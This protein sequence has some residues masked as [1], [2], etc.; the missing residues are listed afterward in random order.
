MAKSKGRVTIYYSKQFN[1]FKIVPIRDVYK[2]KYS[3]FFSKEKHDY[4][5][6]TI[7]NIKDEIQLYRLKDEIHFLPY[8]PVRKLY[9]MNTLEAFDYYSVE[10]DYK[11]PY[12]SKIRSDLE[13]VMTKDIPF[14][15]NGRI[16]LYHTYKILGFIRDTFLAYELSN[17]SDFIK[18]SI[19]RFKKAKQSFKLEYKKY[20]KR[21]LKHKKKNKT[22]TTKLPSSH[23]LTAFVYRTLYYRVKYLKFFLS[24]FAMVG[25]DNLK[26][27]NNN[28]YESNEIKEALTI[29]MSGKVTKEDCANSL[30][31]ILYYYL[32][33]KMRFSKS[34]ALIYSKYLA[35]N[36]FGKVNTYKGS[37]LLS[38]IHIKEV[39]GSHVVFNSS[40]KTIM[41]TEP[42]K[43]YIEHAV[44]QSMQE[45]NIDTNKFPTNEIKPLIN[46]PLKSYILMTPIELL[47]KY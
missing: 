13:Y 32:L 8:L 4:V 19:A 16:Y 6:N 28:D 11:I 26:M 14:K 22:L 25:I 36:I 18:N 2:K 39:I 9:L 29:F 30:V 5:M 1:D 31:I 3:S 12:M 23:L 44:I 37:E 45:L 46:N 10:Q 7:N 43:D 47:Q 21:Y 41:I 40:V 34:D 15:L 20:K 33:F 17:N 27:L 38:N 42:Q 24:Y 35:D